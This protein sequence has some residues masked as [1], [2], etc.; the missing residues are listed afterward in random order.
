MIIFVFFSHNCS[1]KYAHVSKK[2]FQ[3][4]GVLDMSATMFDYQNICW[5]SFKLTIFK[6]LISQ[7]IVEKFYYLKNKLFFIL[8]KAIVS[9]FW[10]KLT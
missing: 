3:I 2:K 1:F 9:H 7:R 4:V 6:F 8:Q 5:R 10:S